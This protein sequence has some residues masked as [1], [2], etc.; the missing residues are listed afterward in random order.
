MDYAFND[1]GGLQSIN[2]LAKKDRG[3]AIS[4]VARQFESFFVAQMM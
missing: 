1:I 3:E 4:Q 2:R